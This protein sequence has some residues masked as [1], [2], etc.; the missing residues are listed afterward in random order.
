M[1]YQA[2]QSST[3]I[4][5]GLA[6]FTLYSHSACVACAVRL[7]CACR[8]GGGRAS[9]SKHHARS[10][11]QPFHSGPSR[12]ISSGC[13]G[14]AAHNLRVNCYRNIT[15]D[16]ACNVPVVS[17]A[18]GRVVALH[19]RLGDTVQKGQVLL[20]IRS[21]DVAGGFDAYRKAVAERQPDQIGELARRFL[22]AVSS[23]R[24][25]RAMRLTR[26][27]YFGQNEAH[28][29]TFTLSATSSLA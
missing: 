21:D 8:S 4:V 28:R 22:E 7:H 19:A 6:P 9:A 27:R 26:R 20:T 11:S 3:A 18:S 14:R 16:I 15:P 25:R 24:D 23:A 12:A 5:H 29:R 2:E 17:L 10:G 13:G 1:P